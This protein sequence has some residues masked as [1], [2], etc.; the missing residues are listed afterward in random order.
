MNY[1]D[2]CTG[3]TAYCFIF[4]AACFTALSFH[5]A[6]LI[7]IILAGAQNRVFPF[8]KNQSFFQSCHVA[9]SIPATPLNSLR[10][11]RRVPH[12]IRRCITLLL[13]SSLS[14]FSSTSTLNWQNL[15][16]EVELAIVIGKKGRFI[17]VEDAPSYIAGYTVAHGP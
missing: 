5:I 15:D 13:S 4:F 7:R 16:F 9:S 11:S 17:S 3:L 12:N 10:S 1:V 6:S 2:H 8:R 14:F